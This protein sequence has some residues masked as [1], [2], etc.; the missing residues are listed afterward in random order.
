M[1][2][3]EIYTVDIHR[4]FYPPIGGENRYQYARP[5]PID[6]SIGVSGG[7]VQGAPGM[8]GVVSRGIFCRIVAKDLSSP[9][10]ASR[11]RLRTP[12]ASKSIPLSGWLSMLCVMKLY[13]GIFHHK[14]VIA[15]CMFDVR[16]K[17]VVYYSNIFVCCSVSSYLPWT[18]A[19]LIGYRFNNRSKIRYSSCR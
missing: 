9:S 3:S 13:A 7:V 1:Y 16:L 5:Q 8:S 19:G 15:I 2:W 6:I 14:A 10:R 12:P 18:S 4:H 11:S 17:P